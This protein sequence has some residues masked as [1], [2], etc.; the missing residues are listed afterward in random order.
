MKTLQKLIMVGLVTLVGTVAGARSSLAFESADN[1]FPGSTNTAWAGIA[2]TYVCS[3]GGCAWSTNTDAISPSGDI[4]YQMIVCGNGVITQI[5][6]WFTASAGDLDI[7][8][9]RP[10]QAFVGSSTGVTGTE[11]VDT[12]TANANALVLKVYG[13]AGATNTYGIDIYCSA[14]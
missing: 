7:Q 14:S 6:I 5:Q 9:Y 12:S 13:Y 11:T 8:V 3:A 10:N 4:D 2:S 1:T